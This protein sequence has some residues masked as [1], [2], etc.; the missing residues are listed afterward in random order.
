MVRNVDNSALRAEIEAWIRA[1]GGT[2]I[3]AGP[4]L[5]GAEILAGKLAEGGPPQVGESASKRSTSPRSEIP[6]SRRRAVNVFGSQP[7]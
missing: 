5:G 1:R 7:Q 2:V 6:M 4:G 3:G